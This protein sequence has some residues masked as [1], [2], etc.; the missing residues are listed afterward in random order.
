[1]RAP[2]CVA[3]YCVSPFEVVVYVEWSPWIF[4]TEYL[5]YHTVK[6]AKEPPRLVLYCTHLWRRPMCCPCMI[7]LIDWLIE[8]P[9]WPT[10]RRHNVR[11]AS[12]FAQN[13]I[14]NHKIPIPFFPRSPPTDPAGSEFFRRTLINTPFHFPQSLDCLA[15]WGGHHSSLNASALSRDRCHFIFFVL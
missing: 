12:S 1:M 2:V 15:F 7:R 4:C 8:L 9:W 11:F 14:R 6:P 3:L 10:R 13:A 5:V